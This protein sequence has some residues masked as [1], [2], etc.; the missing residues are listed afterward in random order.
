MGQIE[1]KR[2]SFWALIPKNRTWEARGFR[3]R[4]A[5][6]LM[7]ALALGLS[8]GLSALGEE[9]PDPYTLEAE[10]RT[11]W[12]REG[13]ETLKK[14]FYGLPF[15][16]RIVVLPASLASIEPYVL[17]DFQEVREYRVAE[18]N[19]SFQAV[20]GVLFTKDGGTL[21][22]FPARKSGGY[23][24]PQGVM[25]IR[26]G[27]FTN[28]TGLKELTLPQGM[29]RI[30]AGLFDREGGAAAY[31]SLERLVLSCTIREASGI[32][33]SCATLKE[34]R[35][36]RD[37]P[38]FYDVDGVLFHRDGTLA[39]Y[40]LG[41][42]A[43]HYD[44][45]AGTL[46]IGEGAFRYHAFLQSVS[47]PQGLKTIGP[48]AFF[49]C[50]YLEAASLPLTVES[51][52]ENAF[53]DCIHLKHIAPPSGV[54]LG[55]RAFENCPLLGLASSGEVPRA[56]TAWEPRTLHGLV[57]PENSREAVTVLSEPRAGAAA[58]GVL[59]CGWFLEVT[60]QKGDFYE[61]SFHF[62]GQDGGS[63]GYLPVEKVQM[64]NYL[65]GLFQPIRAAALP[66][67]EGIPRFGFASVPAGEKGWMLPLKPGETCI[68]W[69]QTGQSL[70]L[71]M[72]GGGFSCAKVS[73]VALY[74]R[75]VPQ[76]KRFGV[77]ISPDTRDRLHLRDAPRKG[78]QSLGKFFSGTQVEILGEE[79]DWYQVRVGFEE[80]YMMKEFIR[81][82]KEW[83]EP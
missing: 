35:V 43:P 51:I 58:A 52:G 29:E 64:V 34:I 73:D 36:P 10:T 45:P 11:L 26:Y 63:G 7:L 65:Q 18:G 56:W 66:G 48:S 4:G 49:R 32:L 71:A 69:R 30:P 21:V 23:A 39:A 44:V 27:A 74:A 76:G 77:V 2:V 78:G 41:K 60:G 25:D 12:V 79:G 53:A 3:V 16:P 80:G 28:N 9:T 20:D 75:E 68:V 82:V 19:P 6:A 8:G 17:Y 22:A 46:A 42:T 59:E 33:L 31:P 50:P 40:P 5:L 61:V 54:R 70:E 1:G 72:E 14:T 38:Y 47:L 37:N 67:K 24:I 13:V 62:P 57:N 15:S 55:E 81:E 83:K